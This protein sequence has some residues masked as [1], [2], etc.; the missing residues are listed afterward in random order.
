MRFRGSI[1][2]ISS[3]ISAGRPFS[4]HV[5]GFPE[6]SQGVGRAGG[7][8]LQFRALIWRGTGGAVITADTGA[9]TAVFSTASAR[10]QGG[11]GSA[12]GGSSKGTPWFKI[13]LPRQLSGSSMITCR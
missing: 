5:M 1:T 3:A 10:G 6:L 8:G 9:S 7:G 2:H 12:A 4:V 11:C 13:V